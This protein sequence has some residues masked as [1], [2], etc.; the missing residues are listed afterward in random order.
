MRL[1]VVLPG[2]EHNAEITHGILARVG[3]HLAE[4]GC[5]RSVAVVSD[6]R[7]MA[8][9]GEALRKSLSTANL[10]PI[11]LLVPESEAGKSMAVAS[12]LYCRLAELRFER[13]DFLIAFG[14]GAIGD[15]AGFVATTYKRGLRLVNVPTSLLA[16][17]DSCLGG[18]NGVNLHDENNQSFAKNAVGTIHQPVGIYVDPTL[19]VTL[20]DE[21]YRSGLGEIAKSCAIAG[22]EL[23]GRILAAAREMEAGRLTARAQLQIV[24]DCLTIKRNIVEKD[25]YD[26]GERRLLNFG[27]TFGHALEAHLGTMPHG[28]CIAVGMNVATKVSSNR[29]LCPPT[30]CTQLTGLLNAL[31]L[32][33]RVSADDAEAAI[34]YITMDKK[35]QDRRLH[36]VLIQRPGRLKIADDVTPEEVAQA[37]REVC[38]G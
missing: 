26:T 13:N 28:L 14:G 8:A 24:R 34:E 3:A 6:E 11:E 25:E 29:G 10:E 38:R 37:A 2:H 27:H 12:D 17:V 22:G 15:L 7:V 21:H 18:K 30:T 5:R 36:F 4:L 23:L 31:D 9:H 20:P 1:R 35:W 33:T 16:Q 32:P 19:P